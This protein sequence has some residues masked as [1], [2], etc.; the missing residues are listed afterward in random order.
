MAEKFV[1]TKELIEKAQGYMPLGEKV[2]L[3]ENIAQMSVVPMKTAQ[4]NEIGNG[5]FAVPPQVTEDGGIK[6]KCLLNV[7]LSYYLDIEIEQ[8]T[9]EMYDYYGGSQIFNQLERLKSNPDVKDK[10]F[11]ILTDYRE[12]KGMVDAQIFAQIRNANDPLARIAAG[13]AVSLTPEKLQELS[14]QLKS[15]RKETETIEKGE[16]DNA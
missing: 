6:R 7:F 12:F 3:A 9:D 8:V 15:V 13:L 5:I 1:I 10:V 4:S 2:L 11:D 14:E 16:S